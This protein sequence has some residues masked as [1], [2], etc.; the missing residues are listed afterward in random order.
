MAEFIKETV[1]TTNGIN[2]GTPVV[3][4]VKEEATKIETASYLI[5]FLFGS[6]E[7]I[8]ALRLIFKI[9]GASTVSN[10]VSFLYNITGLFVMPFEGIFRKAVT[11]GIE[12][13]SVFEP[14]TFVALIVYPL[15]GWAFIRLLIIFSGSKEE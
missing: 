2:N 1:T 4:A 8:L 3:N 14:A 5:Y 7:A 10:F 12:T 6:L 11:Q 15:L 13:V 9:A